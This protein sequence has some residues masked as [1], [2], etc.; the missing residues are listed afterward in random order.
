MHIEHVA[1]WTKDLEKMKAFTKTILMSAVRS[2]ITTRK[3]ASNLILSALIQA[4]AWS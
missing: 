1:I 3:P 4:A 2:F